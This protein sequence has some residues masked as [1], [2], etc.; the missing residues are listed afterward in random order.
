M[1]CLALS[2]ESSSWYVF[3]LP[4]SNQHV[5]L[6]IALTQQRWQHLREPL[7]LCVGNVP[8]SVQVFRQAARH[9]GQGFGRSP[10]PISAWHGCLPLCRNAAW[11]RSL[12]VWPLLCRPIGPE[13]PQAPAAPALR[14]FCVG[15]ERFCLPSPL[16]FPLKL[17][18]IP[19]QQKLCIIQTW[20]LLM[21]AS[22]V[23]FRPAECVWIGLEG[24]Y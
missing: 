18:V 16:I 11:A 13:H 7:L 24:F 14:H 3:F 22:L 5:W 2:D 6:S 9:A 21:D 8:T 4:Q 12:P 1:W 19:S 10:E 15:G 23:A 20:F 17:L